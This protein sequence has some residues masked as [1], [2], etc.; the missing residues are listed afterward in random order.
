[1]LAATGVGAGDLA[2]GAF[3]G[4][5]LGV[6]VLW[7]V[8]L[9]AAFKYV[10][11]EGLTR[12]QLATETTLLEGAA[13]HL[14]R[15]ALWGFLIYLLVWTFGVGAS[16]IS[17]CGVATQALIPVFDDPVPGKI[18]FGIGHSL[19][20]LALVWFG[21]YR[22]IER[23][24]GVLVAVLFLVVV[25][26]G[27]LIGGD[28]IAILK[29]AFVPQVPDAPEAV[30]WTMALMGGVGG[31]LT[32]ICYGYWIRESGRSE[33]EDLTKCRWDIGLSYCMMALFGIAVVILA[34]GLKS[35]NKGV[36][37]VM[38]LANHI[39][40]QIGDGG[41]WLFLIGAWA[42][43]FS[44]LVGVWQA[45]PYLFADF[46]HLFRNAQNK[47]SFE[48]YVVN[49]RGTVY[50]VYLCVLATVPMLGL[51]YDFQTVQKLNSVFGAL[52]M[53][54]LAL[55]LLILNGRRIW[56][57]EAYRNRKISVFALL[58]VL[59]FFSC[60]GLMKFL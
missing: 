2:G 20:G 40:E 22:S 32:V 38:D 6:A 13:L 51:A 5:K 18:Y 31:T 28:L 29:G 42:A 1:M 8:I 54:T 60:L 16:L 41:R 57:G 3:A 49:T 44:S 15:G 24:L 34:D 39:G 55:A 14:G 9:G 7:A 27:V 4:M 36:T 45:V 10:I 47:D 59:V 43:V 37:L 53:P 17:A 23:L 30:D 58:F 56:V 19:L 12:W 33:T 11:T 50:R 52:V 25:T 21:S 35:D 46:W 26:A 48:P